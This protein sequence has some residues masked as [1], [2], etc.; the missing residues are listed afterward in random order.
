MRERSFTK[1]KRDRE[2]PLG[3]DSTIREEYLRTSDGTDG[4]KTTNESALRGGFS[5]RG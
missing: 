3:G 2:I 1:E 5:K 4:R